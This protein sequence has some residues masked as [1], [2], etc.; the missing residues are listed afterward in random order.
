MIDFSHHNMAVAAATTTTATSSINNLLLIERIEVYPPNDDRQYLMSEEKINNILK[1]PEFNTTFESILAKYPDSTIDTRNFHSEIKETFYLENEKAYNFLKHFLWRSDYEIILLQ[2]L[3]PKSAIDYYMLNYYESDGY[4][5]FII[6]AKINLE[7]INYE[8]FKDKLN[9]TYPHT[10]NNYMFIKYL[11][12]QMHYHFQTINN[13][14]N[15]SNENSEIS[16]R[17]SEYSSDYL[18]HLMIDQPTF[19]NY[20]L[21]NYQLANIYWMINRENSS[22]KFIIDN[23]ILVDFDIKHQ[24]NFTTTSLQEKRTILNSPKEN[25]NNF[26]GG[27][28]CDDVGLGKTLQMYILTI[29][30][31]PSINLILVPTH[32][33]EH[34]QQEYIKHI[35]DPEIAQLFVYTGGN[36][37]SF[38]GS[39]PNIILSTFD[40]LTPE[41]LG[42]SYDRLI[43]DEFHELFDY[44]IKK[45]NSYEKIVQINSKFRWAVSATPLINS[46]MIYNIFNFVAKNKIN[47]LNITKYKMYLDIFSDMFRR[48]TKQSILAELE[49]PKIHEQIYYLGLSNKEEL[50]YNSLSITNNYINITK[51]EFIKRQMDFC[52]NPA[53][54]FMDQ[55]GSMC[56][57]KYAD[58]D[59]NI[60]NMHRKDYEKIKEKLYIMKKNILE[61]ENNIIIENIEKTEDILLMWDELIK[62]INSSSSSK[63]LDPFIKDVVIL[64]KDLIATQS[65]MNYFEDQ[66][67]LINELTKEPTIAPDSCA[68]SETATV[69]EPEP[70][71]ELD[72]DYEEISDDKT[73]GICLGD[74][75]CDSILLQCGHIY[76]SECIEMVVSK[77]NNKC[78]SCRTSLKNTTIYKKSQTHKKTSVLNDL[79]E[80]YGTK[81]AHLINI[82]KSDKMI[83]EKIIIYSYSPSLLVNV[84]LILNS[85]GIKSIMPSTNPDEKNISET[86][87]QFRDDETIKVLVLSSEHNASGLN[88]I[89]ASSI[90]ILQPINGDYIYRRQIENQIIGRLH[91]IGQVREIKFIRMIIKNTIE[92][93]IDIENKVSD[94]LYLT[95]KQ[96]NSFMLDTI[97]E[98]KEVVE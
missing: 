3:V 96:N 97:K 67:K 43:V 20:K 77:G 90:I 71:L 24:F 14:G 8:E 92:A 26:I 27:C 94:I 62:K 63:D 85:N 12:T 34:W 6:A 33:L 36:F 31:G 64:E 59:G 18:T 86:I 37:I 61:R 55:V 11:L 70:E 44:N 38:D 69:P 39:K 66:I 65:K 54:Y 46:S 51:T 28:L 17:I 13:L 32:L 41:L 88:I 79:I 87:N 22:K 25:L 98:V 35:K 42:F 57:F 72:S 91:R 19:L 82:C 84:L 29:L 23:T 95:E 9:L 75:S 53:M 81:I 74:L 76:C 1:N 52:I 80:Q 16:K 7:Y 68:D 2:D 56:E 15:D 83:D 60:I 73:C 49:L 58:I 47:L 93:T 21:N 48:N 89:C 50:R 78:P 4:N 5:Y 45:T 30:S 10:P 40:N